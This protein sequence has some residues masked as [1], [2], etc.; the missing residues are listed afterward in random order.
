MAFSCR[1]C[2][3]PLLPRHVQDM[4]PACLQMLATAKQ[5]LEHW[6]RELGLAWPLVEPWLVNDLLMLAG[7]CSSLETM[8]SICKDLDVAGKDCECCVGSAQAV[9]GMACW[10]WLCGW[11]LRLRLRQFAAAHCVAL[12]SGRMLHACCTAACTGCL[13][14]SRTA[15]TG[16]ARHYSLLPVGSDPPHPAVAALRDRC[17]SSA[18]TII[19]LCAGIR[20]NE[21]VNAIG[22]LG[23][24]PALLQVAL[25]V[26]MAQN[27]REA[28]EGERGLG[29]GGVRL[30]GVA[31]LGLCMTCHSPPVHTASTAAPPWATPSTQK[32][33]RS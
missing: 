3:Q 31:L 4:L 12:C 7:A 21:V 10:W 2:S 18:R 5:G 29:H 11:K 25:Q 17:P 28:R 8:A 24:S 33:T 9:C 19:E 26:L 27:A 22:R 20:P 13:Q 14:Y 1:P 15:I 30:L 16:S 32:P 6:A 23:G